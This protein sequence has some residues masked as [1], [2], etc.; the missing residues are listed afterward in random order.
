MQAYGM[1]YLAID[2]FCIGLIF[3]IM[4]YHLL[5]LFADAQRLVNFCFCAVGSE[6]FLAGLLVRR[7]VD[8]SL[9]LPEVELSI[10][11][12]ALPSII[13]YILPPFVMEFTGRLF[14]GT[15]SVRAAPNF[16]G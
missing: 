1:R 3:A 8:Q 14:H 12:R 16:L 2:L 15:I 6:L 13:A 9:F 7:A 5:H 10:C 4:L 11:I